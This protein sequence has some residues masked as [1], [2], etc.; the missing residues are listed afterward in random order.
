[1]DGSRI[2][3]Q[4]RLALRWMLIGAAGLGLSGCGGGGS[5]DDQAT[6]EAGAT[7][8]ERPEPGIP[9]S[10]RFVFASRHITGSFP[11]PRALFADAQRVYMGGWQGQLYV[12]ARSVR[13]GFPVLQRLQV[14]PWPLTAVSG[15]DTRL[16]VTSFDGMLHVFRKLPRADLALEASVPVSTYGPGSVVADAAGLIVGKGQVDLAADRERVYV[17]TLGS[18]D[19]AVRLDKRDFSVQQTYAQEFRR[20]ETQVL[21][22]DSGTRLAVLPWGRVY[23]SGD[24]LALLPPDSRGGP[25]GPGIDLYEPRTLT[26]EQFLPVSFASSVAFNGRRLVGVGAAGILA[27]YDLR[28]RRALLAEGDLRVLTGRRDLLYDIRSS[29]SDEHD[30]L[31]WLANESGGENTPA[32]YVVRLD[33]C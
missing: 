8:G 22:R 28:G 26:H 17:S 31:V 10:I 16:Y 25:W 9:L 27:V 33:D 23:A 18:G 1:M 24:V 11:S 20:I 13:D 6:P 4:R 2:S 30:D 19:L 32:L 7:L 21:D 15:D 5:S 14:S 12:L 29:W 3:P